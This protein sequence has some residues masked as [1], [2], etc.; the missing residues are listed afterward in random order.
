MIRQAYSTYRVENGQILKQMAT[1]SDMRDVVGSDPPM[2]QVTI[3]DVS[4]VISPPE[5]TR[6]D[7]M[8]TQGNPSEKDQVRELK[9]EIE[10][11]VINIYE[12]KDHII[13][14]ACTVQKIFLANKVDEHN[15]PML[16]HMVQIGTNAV[17][18]PHVVQQQP[19]DSPDK[20]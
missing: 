13:L 10:E 2:G 12:T 18:K 5:I 14:V 17:P 20:N 19:K 9:F 6:D 1:I 11:D 8:V 3:N 16:R 7:I 15:N 4:H